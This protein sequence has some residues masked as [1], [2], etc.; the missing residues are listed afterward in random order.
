MLDTTIKEAHLKDAA[1]RTSHNLR[2]TIT[3]KFQKSIRF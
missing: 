1:A 2:K 3:E